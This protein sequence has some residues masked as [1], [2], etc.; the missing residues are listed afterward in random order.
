MTIPQIVGEA[1]ASQSFSATLVLAFAMLSLILAT[2]GLY[3]VLSYLVSQRMTEF[4]IR[5]ALGAQRGE[6][7]RLVLIDGLRPVVIGLA[8]GSA[9]AM[10]TGM[11]I[12]SMLYGTGP[13]DPQVFAVM[14]CS[15]TLTALFATVAPA[16]RACRIKPTQA[17]RME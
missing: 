8:I 5:M 10:A 1:T 17:L 15:L 7:L 16:L 9:G 6:L 12:K 13:V 14:A 4:G 11:L 2:V 3:G